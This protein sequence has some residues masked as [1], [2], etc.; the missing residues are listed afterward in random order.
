VYERNLS[1]YFRI[2]GGI[3]VAMIAMCAFPRSAAAIPAF[4]REYG[5]SC[6][7]CHIT[8]TRRNEFGDLFRK[9]G[10]RWPGAPEADKGARAVEP[11]PMGGGSLFDGFY[12]YRLP[13]SV[14]ATLSSAY[15]TDP[16]A[17]NKVTIGSP[18]LNFVL[19][20]TYGNHIGFFST[21]SGQGAPNE[22][23][24][25]LSRLADRPELNVMVGRFEQS[26][27]VFKTNEAL[28]APFGLGISTLNGHAVSL[29]RNGLEYNGM[30]FDRAFL[31][32]GA[33]QE[34]GPGTDPAYYYHLGT[35]VGGL[36]YGGHEPNLDLDSKSSVL[37]DVVVNLDHWGY[38]SKVQSA[39]GVD[40]ALIRRMGLDLKVRYKEA[41]VWGGSML[42]YD[43]DIQN[44]RPVRN[45]TFFGEGSY[46]VY[47]W[48]TLVYLYQYQDTTQVVRPI[49]SHDAGVVLL[50][51][52][53]IR[54]RL[55]GGHST[56]NHET[57]TLQILMGI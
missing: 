9:W 49:Q 53:N 48:M 41:A 30:F 11:V 16:G 20:G 52:Q 27:T 29:G 17:Q 28:L 55:S 56:A 14:I 35:K 50:P 4:A 3:V 13:L 25:H 15:T 31:A 6:D 42:G 7:T 12:P 51:Y 24:L 5:V 33:V 38:R 23:Y 32:V 44:A 19:G 26:T 39:T 57:A 10:Y 34:G 18:N 36:S 22:F 54:L 1:R 2:A 37:E 40:T 21:W 8:I 46:Q 47:N 45:L 43:A